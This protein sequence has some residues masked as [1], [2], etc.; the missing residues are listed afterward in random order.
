MLLLLCILITSNL[1]ERQ[2]RLAVIVIRDRNINGA[3][4]ALRTMKTFFSIV[5]E[6]IELITMDINGI[7]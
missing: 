7:I 6:T 3:A 4:E 5:G 2:R 1:S